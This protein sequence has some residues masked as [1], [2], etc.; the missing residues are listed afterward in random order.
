MKYKLALL[1]LLFVFLNLSCTAEKTM[2]SRQLSPAGPR[3]GDILW[4]HVVGENI[5]STITIDE[6][7]NI[8]TTGGGCLWSFT[9]DGKLRWKTC[10]LDEGCKRRQQEYPYALGVASSPA[11][12][13]DGEKVY[14]YSLKSSGRYS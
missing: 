1:L 10:P 7:G 13:P 4:Q 12:S 2:N 8:Y 14:K 9:S 11:V 3:E 5:E 6:N